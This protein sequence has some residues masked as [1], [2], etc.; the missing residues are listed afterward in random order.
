MILYPATGH[1][2]IHTL[3]KIEKEKKSEILN[4]R[5]YIARRERWGLHID[6]Y[7][8]HLASFLLKI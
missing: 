3:K 6:Y 2:A 7:S 1:I 5:K 8:L 4:L